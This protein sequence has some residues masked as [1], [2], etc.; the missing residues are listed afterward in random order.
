MIKCRTLI[1]DD[2]AIVR[3]A[4]R[5]LLES[6]GGV[7]VVGEADNGVAAVALAKHLQPD[8]LVLDIAMPHASGVI[9][10]EEIRRWSPGTRVAVF[11]A[12]TGAGV[13]GEVRASDVAGILLKSCSSEE[14]RCGF[15][16]IVAGDQ[17][18]CEQVD[19]ILASAGNMWNLT[20][21]E[22]QVLSFAVRGKTNNEIGNMLGISPKTADNHRT[23]LMRK[24][25]VHSNAELVAFALQ[26]GL[27]DLAPS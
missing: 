11:T 9:A 5:L 2:H 25:N 21:R 27:L 22:R 8:L 20:A 24:L 12:V 26:E 19:A 3:G 4:T 13:L 6:I 10:L 14:L 16:A 1:A 17:Y 15:C 18:M 23:N 7:E